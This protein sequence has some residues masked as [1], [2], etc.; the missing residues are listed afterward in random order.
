MESS[1]ITVMILSTVFILLI[2]TGVGGLALFLG[3]RLTREDV[4]WLQA[5][6]IAFAGGL[7]AMIP[8][9]F[10]G[11]LIGWIVMLILLNKW[12]GCE[13]FPSGVLL[14]LVSG[15]LQAVLGLALAGALVSLS[16]AI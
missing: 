10:A 6:L 9:P 12:C 4:E 8:I 3:A 16:R 5:F 1:N 15:I 11:P 14:I 7:C 2:R 13:S